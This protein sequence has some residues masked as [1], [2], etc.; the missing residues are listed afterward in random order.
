[1]GLRNRN[2]GFLLRQQITPV[3]TLSSTSTYVMPRYAVVTLRCRTAQVTASEETSMKALASILALALVVAF[4]ATAFAGA[5]KTQA[6]CEKA[7]LHWD[8]SAKKCS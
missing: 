1:M 5:P 6:A 7:K 3:A 4:S 8:A 2:L